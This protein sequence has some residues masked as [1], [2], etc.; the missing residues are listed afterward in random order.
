MESYKLKTVGGIFFTYTHVYTDTHT[1]LPLRI[2]GLSALQAFQLENFFKRKVVSCQL[3]SYY[4]RCEWY[5][6]LLYEGLKY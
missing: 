2:K 3:V 6:N 4:H 1:Y 5:Y